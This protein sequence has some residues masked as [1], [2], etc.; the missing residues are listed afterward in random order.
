MG[1]T[2]AIHSQGGSYVSLSKIVGGMACG[3]LLYLGLS[4]AAQADNA[5]SELIAEQT[6]Q[7]QGGQGAGEKQ[8]SE[9]KPGGDSTGGKMIKGEVLR[10]EDNN[11][12]IKGKT[13]KRCGC[14]WT[15]LP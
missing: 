15:L 7:K 9:D 13:A 3:C 5:A 14:I 6:D 11:C 8:V 2:C 1:S 12:F 4:T 10:V